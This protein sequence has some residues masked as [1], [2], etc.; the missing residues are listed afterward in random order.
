MT[1]INKICFI[2]MGLINSSLARTLRRKKFYKISVGNSRS[3]ETLSIVKK[4]N[5]VDFI[6]SDCKEA[7]KEADLVVIGIPVKA[8]QGVL[9]KISN[10][11]KPGCIITDVGSVKLSLVKSFNNFIPK[12][13]FVVPGHP[14]AG[15]ENSGPEAGFDGL[16]E[17]GW[18]ILTP[19]PKLNI[20][21]VNIVKE[22]WEVVGMKVDIMSPSYHD[23][24]LAITS[25]I[26]HIIAYS[27]VGTV[28]NLENSLKK[29]VVKYAASGFKDFTRIA[30][31]DPTMW[32]D[33]ML[34]NKR[35]IL[36]MLTIFK[37]DLASLEK[38]I[39][40]ED[41]DFMYKLFSETRKIRKDII[42]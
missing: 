37:K 26:P 35:A 18:C 13:V 23:M 36:N 28:S 5:I 29:E 34:L 33:I 42:N 27:I 7:V 19:D 21:K 41:A 31:S 6:E 12:N 30:A 2:G 8:Y 39:E 16:F 14:I 20:E 32:R 40:N 24:V 10:H 9:K 38:A 15:T 1:R 22:M 4:L 25:H 17:K 3:K 11:L